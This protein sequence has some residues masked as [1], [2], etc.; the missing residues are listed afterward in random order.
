[1]SRLKYILICIMYFLPA[2][3]CRKQSDTR[4]HCF[5]PCLLFLA[6]LQAAFYWFGLLSSGK[7]II[8]KTYFKKACSYILVTPKEY[9]IGFAAAPDA[10]FLFY[11]YCD[12]SCPPPFLH[13][14]NMAQQRKSGSK[15]QLFCKATDWQLL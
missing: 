12:F 11:S 7:Q 9:S 4:E 10:P 2:A 13:C 6:A 14:V 1:M 15:S 3:P 5:I 8:K